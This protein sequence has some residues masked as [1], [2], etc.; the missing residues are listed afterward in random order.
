MIKEDCK[1]SCTSVT[2]RFR[3]RNQPTK[4]DR[5]VRNAISIYFIRLVN[6]VTKSLVV[7]KGNENVYQLSFAQEWR[8]SLSFS[9]QKLS[10]NLKPTSFD[11][12]CPHI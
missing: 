5:N 6:V 4:S 1:T 11:I 12:F 3:T 10:T 9:V 7:L 8:Q 2:Q